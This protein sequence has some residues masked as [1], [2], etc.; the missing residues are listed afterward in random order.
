MTLPSSG[1]YG[2]CVAKRQCVC[3]EAW[4]TDTSWVTVRKEMKK[5]RRWKSWVEEGKTAWKGSRGGGKQRWWYLSSSCF[6]KGATT[7]SSATVSIIIIIYSNIFSPSFIFM[8]HDIKLKLQIIFLSF[9]LWWVSKQ[10][11]PL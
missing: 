6:H 4:S 5:G 2:S 10:F 3:C 9:F 8:I 11:H 7:S 1:P